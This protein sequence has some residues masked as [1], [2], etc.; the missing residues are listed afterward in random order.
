M[1]T[2]ITFIFAVTFALSNTQEGGLSF[3]RAL[4]DTIPVLIPEPHN[5]SWRTN[6]SFFI[7]ANTKIVVNNPAD[8]AAAIAI[9]QGIV[10]SCA[11]SLEIINTLVAENSII[12]QRRSKP[13]VPYPTHEKSRPQAYTLE[14]NSANCVITGDDHA[15][16]FYGAMTLK[17]LIGQNE[18]DRLSGVMIYDYPNLNFRGTRMHFK[19][20][21]LWLDSMRRRADYF[22]SLKLNKLIL[23]SADLYTNDNAA[24]IENFFKWC[25]N[26]HI[27]PIP[28]L[29]S[30]GHAGNI[31]LQNPAC[32]EGVYRMNEH[33]CFL[34]DT[35]RCLNDSSIFAELGIVDTGFEN[36][37]NHNFGSWHQDDVGTTIFHDATNQRAGSNCVM[38]NNSSYAT[39][40]LWQDVICKKNTLYSLSFHIRT[41]DVFGKSI[42]NSNNPT[43]AGIE[44]YSHRGSDDWQL[45]K[46]SYPLGKTQN[47]RRC[48][49]IFKSGEHETLRV[50]VG[51]YNAQGRVWFDGDRT[52]ILENPGFDEPILRHWRLEN[53]GKGIEISQ[54]TEFGKSDNYS[55]K[56]FVDPERRPSGLYTRL[57]QDV[58]VEPGYDYRI[59]AWVK[60]D[61]VKGRGCFVTAF[62]VTDDGR[63]FWKHRR[64]EFYDFLMS[65]TIA[66][67]SNWT[68]INTGWFS[69]GCCGKIRIKLALDGMGAG[70]FDD[71]SVEKVQNALSNIDFTNP[72]RMTDESGKQYKEDVDFNLITRAQL[73]FPYDLNTT[74]SHIIRTRYSNI[75]DSQIV[76]LSY[77]K[78]PAFQHRRNKYSYCYC[79]IKPATRQ[80]MADIIE[81]AL[82][83]EPEM[84]HFG[85]DEI[86]IMKTDYHCLNSGYTKA[87]LLAYDV[88]ALHETITPIRMMLWED[89][90]NPYHNGN[91]FPDDPTYYAADSIKKDIVLAIWFYRKDEP[92][93][94][95]DSSIAYFG[96]KGF[97]T[98]A[99]SAGYQ[100]V[101]P[102]NWACEIKHRWIDLGDSSCFGLINTT[103]V[104]SW[105]FNNRLWISLPLTLEYSWQWPD[106]TK[107]RNWG[108]LR[109]DPLKLH[110]N[111]GDVFV[112]RPSGLKCKHL[113]GRMTEL[114]WRRNH[115]LDLR[116]YNVYRNF[117][118]LASTADTFYIDHTSPKVGTYCVTAIDTL[119]NE[120]IY[121]R[122][123]V[124]SP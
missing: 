56:V 14:I 106:T 90:L 8:T 42:G 46:R 62:W 12:L 1:N 49:V 92:L 93:T 17:Q 2:A 29:Q 7:D 81:N 107:G 77:A 31:L 21:P 100:P 58:E 26:I 47:W 15:G 123:C 79:P 18:D 99:A 38:I 35:A 88:N 114:T 84:I 50:Y 6:S 85:H 113:G 43:G 120:S 19:G 91:F 28:L 51:L 108:N 59:R 13:Y 63:Q 61:G 83:W 110:R 117:T 16:V 78:L 60:T 20:S 54:N 111:Y 36:V 122:E 98:I 94:L 24:T 105:D 72:I 86:N 101:N 74:P 124:L 102:Y 97:K 118:F 71:V 75:A 67:T 37:I 4:N 23:E 10:E 27:E 95:G 57:Y 22:A 48:S 121:S 89:M 64:A 68:E 119:N 103:W 30:F 3:T 44:I 112:P 11:L 66:G 116:E 76:F 104:H 82:Q 39:S 32:G 70:Y 45:L 96:S 40:R 55:C 52:P 73:I 25:R 109:Y 41:Q 87:G 5:I 115:N 9:R 53:V 69:S 33:F 80:L 65:D 34:N